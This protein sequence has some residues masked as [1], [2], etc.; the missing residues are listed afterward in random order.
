MKRKYVPRR[1]RDVPA[2]M[3]PL[4]YISEDK[5]PTPPP[6]EPERLVRHDIPAIFGG[7]R[8]YYPKVVAKVVNYR[9]MERALNPEPSF[10]IIGPFK[11][12]N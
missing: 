6:P 12:Y 3:Y 7:K 9:K 11:V 8:A 1:V 5:A 4:R 2:S 10:S